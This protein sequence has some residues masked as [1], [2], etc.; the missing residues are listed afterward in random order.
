MRFFE[1]EGF[2]GFADLGLD[3]GAAVVQVRRHTDGLPEARA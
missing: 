2:T 3:E 1:G